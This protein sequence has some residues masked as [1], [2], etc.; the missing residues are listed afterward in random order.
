[1]HDMLGVTTGKTARF[2]KNF[3]A[4]SDSVQAAF[5]AYAKAV[6]ERSFP[7]QEHT[8]KA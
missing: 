5:A 8:F 3:L 1:M 6:R 7:A 2:V 4:E